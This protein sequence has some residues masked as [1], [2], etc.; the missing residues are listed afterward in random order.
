MPHRIRAAASIIPS[1]VALNANPPMTTNETSAA[2]QAI[3]GPNLWC[4]RMI[5]LV[6]KRAP[7][8]A[9]I[10]DT[11]VLC[12]P[13]LMTSMHVVKPS[14]SAVCRTVVRCSKNSEWSAW[15]C[16]TS[17]VKNLFPY[18]ACHKSE[19]EE[20]KHR[21]RQTAFALTHIENAIH[22]WAPRGFCH[23]TENRS[24]DAFVSTASEHKSKEYVHRFLWRLPFFFKPFNVWKK[25]RSMCRH[26]AQSPLRQPLRR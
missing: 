23:R 19:S 14:T 11:V 7:M 3:K 24:V 5:A 9:F 22:R 16:I 4:P 21:H 15:K 12:A 2:D 25:V 20:D 17:P 8:H 26:V 10:S 6:K 1:I 18:S 13:A